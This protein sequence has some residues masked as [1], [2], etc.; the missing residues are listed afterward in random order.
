MWFACQCFL[1]YAEIT[2]GTE[3]ITRTLKSQLN[4]FLA[5]VLQ[6]RE[7]FRSS[8]LEAQILSIGT[9]VDL[10]ACGSRPLHFHLGSNTIVFAATFGQNLSTLLTFHF[11]YGSIHECYWYVVD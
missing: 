3:G 9:G 5:P 7:C 8:Q 2:L 4:R 10:S 11:K 6:H 1:F